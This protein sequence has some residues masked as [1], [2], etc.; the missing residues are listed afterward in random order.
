[1]VVGEHSPA[2]VSKNRFLGEK[3]PPVLY[4]AQEIPEELTEISSV[5]ERLF[6]EM[7]QYSLFDWTW[8]RVDEHPITLI[9]SDQSH[10]HV[11]TRECNGILDISHTPFS[12]TSQRQKSD[13]A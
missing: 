12:L 6:W 7:N 4:M 2:R 1:M 11:F 10:Y 3:H 8:P 9:Q 5:V 13:L